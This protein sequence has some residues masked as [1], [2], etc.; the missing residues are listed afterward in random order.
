MSWTDIMFDINE[1]CKEVFQIR[2]LNLTLYL[3]P[4]R[5]LSYYYENVY[6]T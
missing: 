3:D 2:I 5:T 6:K 4:R 1:Y